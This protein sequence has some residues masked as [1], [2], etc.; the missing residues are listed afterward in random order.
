MSHKTAFQVVD[1]TTHDIPSN[2]SLMG[3][4]MFVMDGD[5]RQILPVV[6]CRTWADEVKSCVKASY[7]WQTC[8]QVALINRH[9]GTPAGRTVSGTV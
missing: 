7:L 8:A 1:K 2:L 3:G 6:P 5:F 9:E 4:V